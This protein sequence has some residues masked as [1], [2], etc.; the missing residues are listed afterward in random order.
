MAFSLFISAAVAATV[1]FGGT[2]ALILAAAT[3]LGAT[4]VEATSWIAAMCLATAVSSLVLSIR[5][6]MP[7]IA[8]W[9]TPGA[10]LIAG[11]TPGI[12]MRAAVG[13]FVFASVLMLLTAAVRP[14]AALVA[15][16]PVP[17]AAAML[18]GVLIR[19][20][21]AVLESAQTAPWL[22][23]PLL[24]VFLLVRLIS[25]MGAIL[26]VLLAGV[27][28]AA[29]QSGS[30]PIPPTFDLPVLVAIVPEVNLGVLIGLG[31]PLYLV[32]MASQNLPGF[33]VLRTFGY[34]PPTRSILTV[35]G[36]A[37][38]ATA[39]LGSHQTNLAAIT[40]AIC[41]G[42]DSHADPRQRWKAGVVYGL[43][44]IGLAVAGASVVAILAKMPPEFI[45]TVAGLA[46]LMPLAAA[47]GAAFTS[48]KERAAAA[49]TL[50][51]TASGI[52][53]VGIGS[54]FWGLMAGL[55]VTGLDTLVKVNRRE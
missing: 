31:L 14:V 24:A 36:L 13:A 19:F 21:V 17:V 50:A 1:G 44:Y 39:F 16:F 18:A 29:F 38:L 33:S 8:A 47:L 10:A 52:A 55:I 26:A 41:A 32:T 20:V 46:L 25:P 27:G 54:A 6:R 23:L 12:G 3:S 30:V 22:V 37:S 53:F 51:V 42:P 28:L 9:S 11:S 4:P 5:H 34:E 43:L 40:A 15:R 49:V 2:V 35:T 48:E 45:K 7:I